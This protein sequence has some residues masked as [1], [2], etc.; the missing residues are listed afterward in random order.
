MKESDDIIRVD[1]TFE[2]VGKLI[3]WTKHKYTWIYKLNGSQKEIKF[4]NS[5]KSG[6]KLILLDGNVIY[7]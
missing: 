3:R 5:V 4:F 7:D 1:S 6:K 2:E